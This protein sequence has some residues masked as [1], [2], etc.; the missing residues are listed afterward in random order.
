MNTLKLFQARPPSIPQVAA[1]YLSDLAE[2][3]GSRSFLPGNRLSA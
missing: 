1:W 2:A 3:R